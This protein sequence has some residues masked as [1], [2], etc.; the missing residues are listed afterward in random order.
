MQAASRAAP[1]GPAWSTFHAIAPE[2]QAVV[3]EMRAMALPHKGEL[4]STAARA[5]FDGIIG[6][7]VAPEGVSFREDPDRRDPRLVV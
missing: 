7:T 4:R 6:S 3:A 5:P 2:D 1:P